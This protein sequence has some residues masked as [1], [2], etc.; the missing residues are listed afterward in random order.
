[1]LIGSCIIFTARNTGITRAIRRIN[2]DREVWLSGELHDLHMRTP[3]AGVAALLK[4]VAA[5]PL[6]ENFLDSSRY[7]LLK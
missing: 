2:Q 1:M 4:C 3:N 7:P 6:V 5:A